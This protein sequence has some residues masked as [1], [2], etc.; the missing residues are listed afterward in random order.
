M[1]SLV[2]AVFFI[3]S[4][5]AFEYNLKPQKI[6]NEVY[7]FFGLPQVIDTHNN[8]NMVNSCFVD[9]GERYLVIDSGPTYAYAKE[10][11][12]KI[13]DIKDQPIAYVINTH[14]HD[15]HWLG[16]SYYKELGVDIIGSVK[17]K[18]EAKLQMT[19]MQRRITKEAY[20]KTTQV[21]PNVFVDKEKTLTINAHKVF[22]KSV[23]KKAHTS[24]DLLIHIPD[25]SALFVGDIVFNDRIPSLR[26]GNIDEWI[27]EL[28]KIKTYNAKY[29][30][31]GHGERVDAHSVDFT[32]DY[33]IELKEKVSSA[34]EDGIEIEDA[35][36]T[37]TMDRYKDTH[38]Y[39]EL[40]RQNV[41][42]AYRTLE[43]EQ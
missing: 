8:G 9:M 2:L 40:Q 43:W 20:E 34:I 26:D 36:K 33:L 1:R 27:K 39:G 6:S 29:I 14:V 17:F 16:N 41:E 4:L 42:T 37:I 5:L 10:A 35:I 25:L 21:F 38:M 12:S 32:Y 7:C 18:N 13:K 31:G 19:R 15:D 28:E 11:Y 22:I 23:N 24:S 3:H 30:I